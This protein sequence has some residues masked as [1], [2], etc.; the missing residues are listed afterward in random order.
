MASPLRTV[1]LLSP[2]PSGT[3][4]A[5]AQLLDAG[6][7]TEVTVQLGGKTDSPA[8]GLYGRPITVRGRVRCI[9]DGWFVVTG[10]MATGSPM[11]LGRTVVLRSGSVDI[12]VSER[13]H[14]P[15]DISCF[16]HAGID[17]VAKRYVL[18]KSRRHFRAGFVPIA[19]HGSWLL[20]Q[21]FAALV[22]VSSALGTCDRPS[23]LWIWMSRATPEPISRR[24][25][26][27]Y[28]NTLWA[29]QGGRIILCRAHSRPF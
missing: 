27:F 21:V 20:G 1:A 8:I 23:I 17:L 11:N 5:V 25:N 9:T 4:K 22:M 26:F 14:E 3:R 10:P 24:T 12:V 6:V 2:D 28:S 16:T 18:I 7:G 13:R 15:F 19:K 29:G